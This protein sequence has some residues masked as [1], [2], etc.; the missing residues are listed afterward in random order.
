MQMCPP[1][2]LIQ[3]KMGQ[4]SWKAS[5]DFFHEPFMHGRHSVITEESARHF[6]V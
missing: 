5:R 6:V 3:Y 4:N 1:M 2:P